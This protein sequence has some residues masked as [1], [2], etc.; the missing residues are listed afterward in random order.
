M[1]TPPDLHG[2]IITVGT[3]WAATNGQECGLLLLRCGPSPFAEDSV[4]HGLC[5]D[6]SPGELGCPCTV[7]AGRGAV[8][9]SDH[10]YPGG[11]V[12]AREVL[13]DKRPEPA[14]PKGR[15]HGESPY[16]N[17]GSRQTRAAFS[18]VSEYRRFLGCPRRCL[19]PRDQLPGTARAR[20]RTSASPPRL[21]DQ[22]PDHVRRE[23]YPAA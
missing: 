21:S 18:Q 13:A 15:T 20:W 14:T 11:T 12:V 10:S 2:A 9:R 16:I 1:P 17:T 23:E 5:T 19:R 3:C 22:L 8:S 7:L 6:R 4:G